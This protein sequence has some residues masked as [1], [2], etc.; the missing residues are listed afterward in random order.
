KGD[1]WSA[2]PGF[3]GTSLLYPV[4][5]S[6]GVH[7]RGLPLERV[8]DLISTTPARRFGLYPKKGAIAVGSDADFA[9]IDVNKE[10]VVTVENSHSAQDHSPFAGKS[11]KG[12]PVATILRGRLA[13]K[14]GAPVGE[15]RGA[16][17][18]RPV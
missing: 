14:D 18:A 7:K 13:F 15:R 1:T 9:L 6:E 12:W 10:Q 8:V 5:L 11:L 3:G 2:L 16:F 4:L 17:V